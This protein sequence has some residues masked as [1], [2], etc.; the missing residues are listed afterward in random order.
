MPVLFTT[1]ECV[2]CLGEVYPVCAGSAVL[3]DAVSCFHHS[4]QAG[5]SATLSTP[6]LPTPQ[7]P[8]YCALEVED[9]PA[10]VYW[11]VRNKD[12]R[13]VVS[14]TLE[15]DIRFSVSCKFHIFGSE[16]EAREYEDPPARL[17]PELLI[18]TMKDDLIAKGKIPEDWASADCPLYKLGYSFY[19]EYIQALAPTTKHVEKTW[20]AFL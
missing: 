5:R 4:Q 7:L 20:A 18:Q 9:T 10:G 12:T 6:A 14:R 15:E 8:D 16:R 2:K 1:F 11:I 19:K 13:E 17:T 3:I